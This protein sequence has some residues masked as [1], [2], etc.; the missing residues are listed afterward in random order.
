LEA[1]RAAALQEEEAAHRRAQALAAESIALAK[2]RRESSE[3][4][5]ILLSECAEK[6]Y[7]I[8]RDHED[9]SKQ[10]KE[11]VG[12]KKK[13]AEDNTDTMFDAGKAAKREQTLQNDIRL[14]EKENATLV[15]DKDRL[16]AE[17]ES[18]QASDPGGHPS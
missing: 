13:G 11:L 1:A 2:E 15:K 4:D 7:R 14:L 16:R 17:I 6:I 9:L 8:G 10:H 3:A 18:L 5:S 12:L